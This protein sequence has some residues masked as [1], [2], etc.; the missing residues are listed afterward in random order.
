MRGTFDD[1]GAVIVRIYLAGAPGPGAAHA[2]DHNASWCVSVTMTLPVTEL[3][4]F[5]LSRVC[6]RT[7]RHIN[8]ITSSQN[9]AVDIL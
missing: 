5:I 6:A 2:P 3:A 8:A 9:R 4:V 1:Q 7:P